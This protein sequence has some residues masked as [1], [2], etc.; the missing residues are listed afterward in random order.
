MH[1]LFTLYLNLVWN[2]IF[3]SP[4]SFQ[5][6]QKKSGC[7][8][9]ETCNSFQTSCIFM[10]SVVSILLPELAKFV[11]YKVPFLFRCI[12]A[13]QKRKCLILTTNKLSKLS[14]ENTDLKCSSYACFLRSQDFSLERCLAQAH[15]AR[16]N[17]IE[18][19][20]GIASSLQYQT[21]MF[22]FPDTE[23][24]ISSYGQEPQNTHTHLRQM[25]QLQ[26]CEN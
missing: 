13:L 4:P 5:F 8:I 26:K 23:K 11:I 19:N 16:R 2:F 20:Y 9:S 21:R 15:D 3:A 25:R 7:L 12:L 18:E 14:F 24:H 10:H 6:K 1:S 17:T 22:K